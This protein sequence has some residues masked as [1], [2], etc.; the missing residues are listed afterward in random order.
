M[1]GLGDGTRRGVYRTS[2]MCSESK[3]GDQSRTQ[4]RN[5]PKREVDRVDNIVW[6]SER[7]SVNKSRQS[8]KLFNVIDN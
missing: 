7:D 1:V 8:Q 6:S 3:G 5:G 4:R 2:R